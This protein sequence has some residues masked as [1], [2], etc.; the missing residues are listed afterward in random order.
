M[1]PIQMKTTAMC[2]SHWLKYSKPRPALVLPPSGGVGGAAQ[3]PVAVRL[4]DRLC[5]RVRE[6]VRVWV[7]VRMRVRVRMWMRMRMG[8]RMERLRL[9]L[10]LGLHLRLR[11]GLRHGLELGLGLGL[12][13][14][15]LGL[16]LDQMLL[17]LPR[18]L[19]RQ[20][21][22]TVLVLHHL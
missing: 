15:L 20:D 11:L 14:R 10:G 16:L 18:G 3:K 17:L 13:L 1:F 9:G 6:L 12:E 4:G 2:S 19:D 7:R 21:G 22:L 5:V 8:I